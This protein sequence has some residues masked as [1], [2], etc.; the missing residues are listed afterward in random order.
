MSILPLWA[1]NRCFGSGYGARGVRIPVPAKEATNAA[2]LVLLRGKQ[3]NLLAAEVLTRRN[4]SGTYFL[5]YTER[6]EAVEAVVVVEGVGRDTE[7]AVLVFGRVE[8]PGAVILSGPLLLG[9]SKPGGR[10]GG[11]IVGDA[12]EGVEE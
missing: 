2:K 11:D 1:G 7:A 9:G 4:H 8:E 3:A 6:E 5:A 10:T 12:G